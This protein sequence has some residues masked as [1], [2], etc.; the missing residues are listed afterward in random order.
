MGKEN[1]I[2]SKIPDEEWGNKFQITINFKKQTNKTNI[3][4]SL[5]IL[6]N[7]SKNWPKHERPETWIIGKNQSNDIDKSNYIFEK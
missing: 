7:F 1:F 3:E 6:K 2:V 4:Y 5:K